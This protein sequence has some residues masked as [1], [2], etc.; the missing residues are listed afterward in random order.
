MSQRW[1]GPLAGFLFF[2]GTLFPALGFFNVYPF[3]FSFVADHFQYLACLG[4]IVPCAAGMVRLADF[5]MPRKPWLQSSLCAGLLLLLGLLSWQRVHVYE[6]NETLWSDT[7]AKNPDCWLADNNFGAILFERGQVDE[8]MAHYQKA[9]ALNPRYADALTNLGVVLARKGQLDG[10][11]V[12]YRE[13]LKIY[14]TYYKALNNLGNAL[15]HKGQIDDAMVQYQKALA[16]NPDLAE[17]HCNLG[18]ALFEKGQNDDAITQFQKALDLNPDYV[19]ARKKLAIAQAMA[20]QK[21][22]QK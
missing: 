21:A 2:A 9:L 15:L 1:R 20:P 5:V 17:V 18:V 10:A 6:N 12:E 14:P 8:A 22:V 19:D 16:I 3:R 7:L 13:A 4:V 11:I